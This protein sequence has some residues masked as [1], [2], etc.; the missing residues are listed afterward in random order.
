MTWRGSTTIQDKIFA[1]LP[2]LLP[3]IA[4][5]TLQ[6]VLLYIYQPVSVGLLPLSILVPD[7]VIQLQ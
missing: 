1:S 4:G 6:V 3:L 2:Y 5:L 7:A